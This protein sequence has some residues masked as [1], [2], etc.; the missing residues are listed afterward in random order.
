MSQNLRRLLRA[1]P[2]QN[3]SKMA[4]RYWVFPF[5]HSFLGASNAYNNIPLKKPE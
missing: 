3:Q 5:P 4:A 2:T 1:T